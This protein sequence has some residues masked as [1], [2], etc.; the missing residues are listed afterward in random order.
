MRE[1]SETDLLQAV[2]EDLIQKS[3]EQ[4]TNGL[5][6]RGGS[7]RIGNPHCYN[8]VDGLVGNLEPL[9]ENM[10][11]R[12][13]IPA[14]PSHM[15]LNIEDQSIT[16]WTNQISS[17]V[18]NQ[19][20]SITQDPASTSQTNQESPSIDIA[21]GYYPALPGML[22]TEPVNRTIPTNPAP[23]FTIGNYGNGLFDLMSPVGLTASHDGKTV[24][25]SD[26]DKNRILIYDMDSSQIQGVIKC[27]MEIKDLAISTMGHIVVA[28]S[29]TGSPLAQAY[30]M[31]GDKILALGRKL[32]LNFTEKMSISNNNQSSH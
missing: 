3:I 18:N 31:E 13:Q 20:N 6:L 14:T 10:A 25:V 2:L 16:R 15:R 23:M 7:R 4:E 26:Q 32:K 27:D 1:S 24:L 30:T 12:G 9:I 29:K 17:T 19:S 5:I 11:T 8:G 22:N 28:S 21:P